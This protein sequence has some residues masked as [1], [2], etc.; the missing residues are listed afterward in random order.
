MYESNF[1]ILVC[2]NSDLVNVYYHAYLLQGI[3]Q[4]VSRGLPVY[5]K[6]LNQ[7]CFSSKSTASSQ[8][9]GILKA[10]A[11]EEV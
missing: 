6:E 1:N 2:N 5:S 10:L 4:A 9:S 3:G 7:R 8:P 11:F